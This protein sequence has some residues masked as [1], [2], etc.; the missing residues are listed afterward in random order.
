MRDINY[1]IAIDTR[2]LGEAAADDGDE[3]V[4]NLVLRFMNS[5]LR[6]TLNAKE[7]MPRRYRPPVTSTTTRKSATT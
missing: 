5:Y 3:Q 6:A 1:L 2:Y 7:G 4:T